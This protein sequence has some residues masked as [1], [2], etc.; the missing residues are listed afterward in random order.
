MNFTRS[1]TF[2]KKI[3]RADKYLRTAF[4]ER[5]SIFIENPFN[6]LLNNHALRGKHQHERSINITSDYRLIYE[7]V[8]SEAIRLLDIDTHHNLYGK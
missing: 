4:A 5:M 8:G 6:P 7:I 3:A 2:D 1:R